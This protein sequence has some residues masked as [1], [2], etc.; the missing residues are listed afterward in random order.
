MDVSD[1][2]HKVFFPGFGYS[3]KAACSSPL[4]C[5]TCAQYSR[6]SCLRCMV[7][8]TG[9]AK[10]IL[11]IH[12]ML[13]ELFENKFHSRFNKLYVATFRIIEKLSIKF[14]DHVIIRITFGEKNNCATADEN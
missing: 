10:I 4:R 14:V 2:K 11:D 5:H 3:Y 6:L 13:P 9:R 12:D 8:E 1:T 7:P